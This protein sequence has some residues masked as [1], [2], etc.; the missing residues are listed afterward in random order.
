MTSAVMREMIRYFGN[1][2]KRINHALKVH[3]FARLIAEL[4]GLPEKKREVLELCAILHD[5]GIHEAERKHG[6]AA[7]KY[8]EAEGPKVAEGI[9]QKCGTDG[10]IVPRVLFLIGN[11]HSYGKIDDIDFR[12]LVEADF[13][14]NL[15]ED[16]ADAATAAAAARKVFRTKTGLGLISSMY[17]A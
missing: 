14:V 15:Y 11:H 1:D 6:S 10:G 7:G 16:G 8:Q 17:P 4:E 12:M 2:V 3:A 9:L 13:L 5:I